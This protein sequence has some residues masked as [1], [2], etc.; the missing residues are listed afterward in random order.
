MSSGALFK[1]PGDS[2]KEKELLESWLLTLESVQWK[3]EGTVKFLIISR[4]VRSLG[5][6]IA[7][8]FGSVTWKMWLVSIRKVVFNPR[9]KKRGVIILVSLTSVYR[10][11]CLSVIWC[12][13]FR[14]KVCV[15]AMVFNYNF[16]KLVQPFEDYNH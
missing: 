14:K 6:F 16:R 11:I 10:C 12:S 9:T 4:S 5:S 13:F 7:S 3:D 2:R 1:V 15:I 8:F